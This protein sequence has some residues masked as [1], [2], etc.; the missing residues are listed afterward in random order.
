[1]K[2]ENN[3]ELEDNRDKIR[4]HQGRKIVALKPPMH[5]D[6]PKKARRKTTH[7]KKDNQTNVTTQN[8]KKYFTTQTTK[9]SNNTSSLSHNTQPTNMCEMKTLVPGQISTSRTNV[10]AGCS[11]LPDEQI[12]GQNM[13]WSEHQKSN[14]SEQWIPNPKPVLTNLIHFHHPPQK[15]NVFNISA[16]TDPILMKL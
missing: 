1:M 2:T 3:P 5:K 9:C 4:Q 6:N 15:L 8:I 10:T 14:Q 13:T 7:K 16:V 12:S 11:V